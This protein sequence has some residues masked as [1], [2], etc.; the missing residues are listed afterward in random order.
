MEMKQFQRKLDERTMEYEKYFRLYFF[1]VFI[2]LSQS[3]PDS[4]ILST[5]FRHYPS[6]SVS[7]ANSK[8]NYTNTLS[9]SNLNSLVH[10]LF[11]ENDLLLAQNKS[12]LLSL[13]GNID[14]SFYSFRDL[15]E[16]FP[17]EDFGPFFNYYE[18][19]TQENNKLQEKIA[20]LSIYK[21]SV[22][23]NIPEARQLPTGLIKKKNII[24]QQK[25]MD[26]ISRSKTFSNFGSSSLHVDF[27][28]INDQAQEIGDR[29][30]Q[31]VKQDLDNT[32]LDKNALKMVR[33]QLLTKAQKFD[34]EPDVDLNTLS[35][36]LNQVESEFSVLS[37]EKSSL[38]SQIQALK[39]KQTANPQKVE[40]N[41]V[42]Q[43]EDKIVDLDNMIIKNNCLLEKLQQEN[44]ELENI[45]IKNHYK[46]NMD[47]SLFNM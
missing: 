24:E 11:M 19:L 1:S 4:D 39:P 16:Q 40:V 9:E 6:E 37:E 10:Q 8:S 15:T 21:P 36:A 46:E 17:D 29:I 18:L 41:E 5:V 26:I 3:P 30:K 45:L 13:L 47:Q 43:M 27:L 38:L 14:S 34:Q 23:L 22:K 20:K 42:N 33:S 35:A 44:K 25:S 32:G 31:L 12:K 2:G 7:K 28:N